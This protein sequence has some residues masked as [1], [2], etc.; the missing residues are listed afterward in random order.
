[1][2]QAVWLF[3][4]PINGCACYALN[5]GQDASFFIGEGQFKAGSTAQKMIL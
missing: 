2:P 4:F 5:K 3:F 1:M